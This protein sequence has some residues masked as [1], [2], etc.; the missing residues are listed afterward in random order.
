MS[1]LDRLEGYRGN[2][3]KGR[4]EDSVESSYFDVR[5]PEGCFLNLL[6]KHGFTMLDTV[7]GEE[8]EICKVLKTDGNI[9]IQAVAGS[10]KTTTLIY[11]IMH[12][13]V[14]G[15]T[16]RVQ[17]LPNG[18]QAK[19]VDKVFV[20][21][22]LK[23][24]ADELQ[25]RLAQ[26]QRK[27]GYSVTATQVT[28]GTLHAE[29]KR[30]LNAMGVATPI[31]SQSV[32]SGLLRKA[33]NSCNI[34]RNGE[35]LKNE[36]YKIIEGILTYYRGRLDE[37]RYRH[38][39]AVDYELTPSIIDLLNKQYSNF[40]AVEGVMDFEDLQELLYKYCYVTPNPAVIEFLGN[41]YNYMYLDEFQD[42]SQIQYALIQVY[43]KGVSKSAELRK[44]GKLIVVG[45]VQQCIYSFRGSDIN[46]MYKQFDEDFDSTHLN[47][48]YNRR[49]PSNILKPII[50]SI[51]LNRE[52][53]GIEIKAINDGGE[54][55][56]RGYQNIKQMLMGV[57][58]ELKK[59][60][61]NNYS[62][63]ILCRTNYDGMIPALYLELVGGFDYSIS[64]E[65]M[66][67]TGALPRK[68]MRVTSIFTDR[69]T[70]ALK[71][72]LS[73]FAPYSQLWG[74]KQLCDTMKQ[75][76]KR[77]WDIPIDDMV[78]SCSAIASYVNDWVEL[79]KNSNDIEVLKAIY[80]QLYED[81]FDGDSAYSQGARAIIDVLLFLLE[82]E[83]IKDIGM[84]RERCELI[85]E[86]LHARIGINADISIATV[87][88]F[89]GK[90]RDAIYVWNDSDGVFPTNKTDMK[91]EF[92]VSEERRVHYIACTR[93]KKKSIILCKTAEVGYFVKEMDCKCRYIAPKVNGSI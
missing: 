17:E 26:E 5:T 18:M 31:A 90:E 61:V 88:E 81:V 48:S 3:G 12:D 22:F 51:M 71:E 72:T 50:P 7:T 13:I 35:K 47:L 79:R 69:G 82:N 92:E 41:R 46:V 11:K 21:T 15:E 6:Q 86:Q 40:K 55:D 14:T 23:S 75:N 65:A 10:G 49:C 62:S 89:K 60:K 70:P 76:Q 34:S 28:F 74:V 52:S 83:D 43:M 9:Y 91:N 59:D 84:F 29:F 67:L 38:P 87:H 93:A 2:L 44:K 73:M 78:Y 56:C 8:T 1:A 57:E 63:G 20:G 66:T 68:L 80:W 16:M 58:G 54:F 64:S 27:L 37:Q 33:I 24:G 77:I 85:D 30:A 45:D 32:L 53:S 39:N 19:V 42:T 25:K 4:T 36:D